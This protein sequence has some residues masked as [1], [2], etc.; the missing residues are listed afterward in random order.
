[1]LFRLGRFEETEK[2]LVDAAAHRGMTPDILAVRYRLAL[3]KQDR[4]GA[5][6]AVAMSHAQSENELGM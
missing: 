1:M 2:A 6:A 5:D 4:A 3:L